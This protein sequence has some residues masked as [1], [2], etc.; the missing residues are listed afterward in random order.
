MKNRILFSVLVFFWNS[1]ASAATAGSA[2][3]EPAAGASASSGS[4]APDTVLMGDARIFSVDPE[5]AL[6]FS[7]EGV[8]RKEG[9]GDFPWLL[10][11]P[12]PEDGDA[13]YQYMGEGQPRASEVMGKFAEG[14][15]R[16]EARVKAMVQGWIKANKAGSP[17]GGLMLCAAEADEELGLEP[18][19]AFG[20]LAVLGFDSKPAGVG[21]L[22]FL[23]GI[24]ELWGRGIMGSV[25]KTVI[26]K[27]APEVK[28][29]GESGE[30]PEFLFQGA[31][32]SGIEA[33]VRPDNIASLVLLM[34]HGALPLT[35]KCEAEDVLVDL[36]EVEH[37]VWISVLRDAYLDRVGPEGGQQYFYVRGP[38][39]EIFV[40]TR[41]P[42]YVAAGAPE[43]ETGRFYLFKE[44]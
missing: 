21:F 28:V 31:P 41:D 20:F 29:L 3:A 6:R 7:L 22:A 27:W 44:V 17:A 40:Y 30:H 19:K 10:R 33:C 14:L 16:E 5:G 18:G 8:A 15:P 1:F 38:E 36:S 35:K 37:S 26:E 34:R 11:E 32:L 42:Q 24:P 9:A 12:R 2:T 13:L 39:G 4:A 43:T 23:I 25:L